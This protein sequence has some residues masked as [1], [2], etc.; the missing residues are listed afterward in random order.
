MALLPLGSANKA[1]PTAT[2][3]ELGLDSADGELRLLQSAHLDVDV[4][5]GGEGNFISSCDLHIYVSFCNRNVYH[6]S[7]QS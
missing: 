7:S 6:L 4:D 5:P 3:T 2:Y 1:C